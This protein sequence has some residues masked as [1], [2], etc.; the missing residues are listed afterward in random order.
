LFA[1]A[2]RW[3]RRTIEFGKAHNVLLAQ[4]SGYEFLG[5]NA[6]STGAWEAACEYAEREREIAARLHSR[7]RAVWT[8]LYAGLSRVLLGEAAR[9]HDELTSGIALAET[10]GERRAALLMY[11]YLAMAEAQLGNPEKAERTAEAAV[12]RADAANLLYMRTET[13][14]VL[15]ETR[16]RLGKT[17]AGVQLFEEV[18]RLTDGTD[19]RVSRLWVGPRHVEALLALGRREEARS[20]FDAYVELVALCQSP[21]F[22]R[23]VVRVRTLFD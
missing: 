2:D 13:K 4:A 6:C 22:D 19:A 21:Y 5:E 10:I 9:A 15:A 14:R 20:R 7:E 3:A 16:I 12:A 11:A 8:H 1:D 18:L 23:E 17:E